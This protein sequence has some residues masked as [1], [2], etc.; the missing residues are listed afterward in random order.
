MAL[1]L[2]HNGSGMFAVVVLI[3]EMVGG[4]AYDAQPCVS[5]DSYV[6]TS[7]IARL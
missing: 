4:F 1:M 2:G 3:P 6:Q 7:L 5:Q